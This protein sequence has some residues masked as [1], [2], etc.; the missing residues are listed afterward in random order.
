MNKDKITVN[1]PNLADDTSR[2]VSTRNLIPPTRQ[3]SKVDKDHWVEK[4]CGQK[5]IDKKDVDKTKEK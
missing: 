3:F 5:N 1:E 4:L 2:S